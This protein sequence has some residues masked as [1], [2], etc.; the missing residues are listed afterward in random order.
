V[1]RDQGRGWRRLLAAQE[2]IM[3]IKKNGAK[4]PAIG[5]G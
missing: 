5:E 4:A 2:K 1:G 3:Q